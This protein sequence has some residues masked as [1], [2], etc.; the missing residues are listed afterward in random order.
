MASDLVDWVLVD[1]LEVPLFTSDFLMTAIG[2]VLELFEFEFAPHYALVHL[3]CQ[4]YTQGYPLFNLL[5]I[6]RNGCRRGATSLFVV[7]H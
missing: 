3:V 6:R 5:N 1:L 4:N 7:P 2:L